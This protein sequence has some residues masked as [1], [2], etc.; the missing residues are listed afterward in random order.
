ML[1]PRQTSTGRNWPTRGVFVRQLSP[2]T[3]ME[4]FAQVNIRSS[5]GLEVPSL[6]N[7]ANDSLF[8]RALLQS[9]LAFVWT[10]CQAVFS[11]GEKPPLESKIKPSINCFSGP[12]TV[13]YPPCSVRRDGESSNTLSSIWDIEVTLS[14]SLSLSFSLC[15]SSLY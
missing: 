4:M 11:Q 8:P 7:P 12:S 2:W 15:L 14:L 1:P 9:H 10:L 5:W 6:V 13:L 3:P